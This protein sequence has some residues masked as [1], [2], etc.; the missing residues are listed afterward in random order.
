VRGG[1]VELVTE[2]RRRDCILDELYVRDRGQGLAW[3]M[4]QIMA[5]AHAAGASAMFL[6]THARNKRARLSYQRCGFTAEDSVWMA[7]ALP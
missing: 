6:E 3:A 5:T 4:P 7:C 1:H 2:V